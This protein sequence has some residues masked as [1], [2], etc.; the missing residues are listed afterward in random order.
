MEPTTVPPATLRPLGIGELLDRAVTLCVKH[1][2]TFAAIAL[3]LYIPIAIFQYFA[4]LE[5]T[6]VFGDIAAGLTKGGGEKPDPAAIMRALERAQPLRGPLFGMVSLAALIGPLT[7]AALVLA[8]SRA[9][10]GAQPRFAD[11]YRAALVR[12]LPLIGLNI[13]YVIAFVVLYLILIIALVL[14]SLVLVPVIAAL[15]GFGVALA[16]ILGIL[17]ALGILLVF[18]LSYLAWQV[19]FLGCVLERSSVFASFASGIARVFGRPALRRSLL[20][21]LALIAIWIGI[22]L[23]S[24]VGEATT[25]GL[26]RNQAVAVAFSTVLRVATVAFTTAF[27]AMFYYDLRVRAEGLDLQLAVEA[28]QSVPAPT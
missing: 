26:I 2:I 6:K 16:V 7:S 17:F 4:T 5:Q 22:V 10:F 1:F 13:V 18:L 12:W 3:V 19:S 28:T 27:V 15:H 14:M 25:I 11:A 24:V 21:G 8:I 20:V 9:Y 23:V